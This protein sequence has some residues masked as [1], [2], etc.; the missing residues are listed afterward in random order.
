VTY[1]QAKARLRLPDDRE[2]ATV[3]EMI[4]EATAIVLTF[5]KRRDNEWTADT[6]PAA[7]QDFAIVQAGI[8]YELGILWRFRGD[9]A[10]QKPEDPAAGAYQDAK[11]RRILH[12]LRRP[13]LA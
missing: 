13:S 2:Q 1:A 4:A 5:A 7:D 11:L 12:P 9:D 8:F 10:D 6:D 3:E